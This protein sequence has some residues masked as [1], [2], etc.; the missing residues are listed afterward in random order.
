MG[1]EVVRWARRS[2]LQKL[3]R[4]GVISCGMWFPGLRP[5]SKSRTLKLVVLISAVKTSQLE[6][7]KEGRK[8]A[9]KEARRAGRKEGRQEG[10]K[11]GRQEGRK[12][13]RKAGRKE[14]RKEARK[15]GSKSPSLLHPDIGTV[16]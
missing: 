7:R 15:Q 13:G 1:T 8:E 2:P 3:G 16:R 11:E 10:R 14:W 5:P 9:R 4:L 12:E 6:A